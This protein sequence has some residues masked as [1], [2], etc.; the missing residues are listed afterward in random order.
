MAFFQSRGERVG[1]R[2]F[3]EPSLA[4]HPSP[5]NT[6]QYT[7]S[8]WM[9]S[10][11]LPTT[12][13]NIPRHR[14]LGRSSHGRKR[15]ITTEFGSWMNGFELGITG[16]TYNR[17]DRNHWIWINVVMFRALVVL[18]FECPSASRHSQ[19]T[20]FI[21]VSSWLFQPSHWLILSQFPW[22]YASFCGIKKNPQK[23]ET[24]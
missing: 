5:T 23:E 8:T 2:N 24:N 4:I 16:M 20:G 6:Y 15:F 13:Q 9:I 22:S 21:S 19:E 7:V 1:P 3:C 10:E 12:T 14:R 11:Q 17:P 18:G